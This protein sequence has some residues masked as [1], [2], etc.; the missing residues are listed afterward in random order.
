[1]DNYKINDLRQSDE[2]QMAN[3][4]WSVDNKRVRII[5]LNPAVG[6]PKWMQKQRAEN[7]P[8]MYNEDLPGKSSPRMRSGA[9]PQRAHVLIPPTTTREVEGMLLMRVGF[10]KPTDEDRMAM[11]VEVKFNPGEHMNMDFQRHIVIESYLEAHPEDTQ[12]GE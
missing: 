5:D 8:P 3:V 12:G 4:P 11:L 7:I 9:R 6:P 1:M 10:L 2:R